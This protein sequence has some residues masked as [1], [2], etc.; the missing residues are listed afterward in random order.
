MESLV[1]GVLTIY[2]GGHLCAAEVYFAKEIG[3]N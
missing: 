3:L 2:A 1:P